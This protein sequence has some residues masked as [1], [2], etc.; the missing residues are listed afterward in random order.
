MGYVGGVISSPV[1]MSDVQSAL[2][3]TSTDLGTLCQHVNINM[4]AKFKPIYYSTVELLNNTVRAAQNYGITNIPTWTDIVK[5]AAFWFGDRASEQINTPECGYQ[6]MYW[7]YKKPMGGASSPFRL[8][9]FSE[10]PIS[11]GNLGYFHGAPAPIASS[12][13]TNY[14]AAAGTSN[15]RILYTA[16]IN[17]NPRCL[18]L[19]DLSYPGAQLSVNNMYFGVMLKK[20]GSSPVKYYAVTQTTTMSQ[21]AQYGAWV[22]IT[23]YS[24]DDGVYEIFPFCSNQPIS[25]TSNLSGIS[26]NRFIAFLEKETIAIG[27]QIVTL[28]VVEATF[29]AYY[30]LSESTRNLY[31]YFMLDNTNYSGA[32][33]FTYSIE[34]FNSSGTVIKTVTGR[35]GTAPASSYH[36]VSHVAI[37]MASQADL[38][39]AYSL[40]LT[41]T[42]TG[43]ANVGNSYAVCEVTNG[44]GRG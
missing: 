39:R 29:S 13:V 28:P 1:S 36:N 23:W 24:G 17:S 6:P 16:G 14:T 33:T 19:S 26:A 38:I 44:P 22:D 40:R 30:D 3:S 32:V 20:V 12:G 37:D 21:L 2:G 15:V 10:Y 42:P 4:W 5:M 11:A 8:A 34:V 35:T 9:D 43:L 27:T 25:F 31:Y 41:V 7:E 18:Q